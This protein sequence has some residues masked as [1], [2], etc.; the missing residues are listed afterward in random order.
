[1][2]LKLDAAIQQ[3]TGLYKSNQIFANYFLIVVFLNK[4]S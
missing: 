2:L 3:S 4:S 1:M